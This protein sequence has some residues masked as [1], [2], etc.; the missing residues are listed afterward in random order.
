M[1]LQDS[2]SKL[3]SG[4]KSTLLDVYDKYCTYNGKKTAAKP[5]TNQMFCL[6]LN[7]S[8]LTQ[9]NFAANSTTIWLSLYHFQKTLTKSNYM[10]PKVNTPHTQCVHRIQLQ[11]ITPKYDNDEI[12]VAVDDFRPNPRLNKQSSVHEI[13][14]FDPEQSFED[15]T[16]Y[17]SP[18]TLQKM[19]MNYNILYKVPSLDLQMRPQLSHRSQHQLEYQHKLMLHLFF[20]GQ[21]NAP[22]LNTNST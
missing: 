12:F 22:V 19:T 15:T 9:S 14:D 16:L 18:D 17:H 6:L 13:F 2:L 20:M 5:L 21:A 11:P 1:V 7:R 10:T 3:F 4:T 8:L